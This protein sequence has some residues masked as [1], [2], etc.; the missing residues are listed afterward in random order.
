MSIHE[1]LVKIKQMADR[2]VME[3]RKVAKRLLN[4]LLKK[5]DMTIE[6]LTTDQTSTCWLRYKYP[7]ERDLIIQILCRILDTNRLSILKRK[8]RKV[9]GI[10]LTPRQHA[11]FNEF[12]STYRKP[13]TQ[14]VHAYIDS[15]F[16][17]FCSKHRLFS[18]HTKESSE[19][20]TDEEIQRLR[21][22]LHGLN[23]IVSPT[24]QIGD[25]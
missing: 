23:D 16:H 7:Y 21:Q 19:V 18:S 14:E 20:V 6:E 12:W 13:L 5:H 10:G 17:A 4:D 3:E 24:K 11:E 8:G 15:V 9:I 25:T 22:V 2:G 1:R